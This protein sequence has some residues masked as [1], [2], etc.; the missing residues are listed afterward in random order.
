M[1]I[2]ELAELAGVS[3]S[4]VSKI[5]NNKDS[6]I[7]SHHERARTADCQAVQLSVLLFP[8]REGNNDIDAGRCVPLRTHHESDFG[9]HSAGSTGRRIHHSAAGERR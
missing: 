1:N 3:A 5:M 8:D 4:T 6:S 7:Q 2:R 9:R